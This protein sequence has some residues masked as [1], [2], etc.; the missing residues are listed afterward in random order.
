MSQ[1]NILSASLED[2]E[3]DAKNMHNLYQNNGDVKNS[4]FFLKVSC[5]LHK[6]QKYMKEKDV[7]QSFNDGDCLN[8]SR[9]SDFLSDCLDEIL[10][11]CLSYLKY[12]DDNIDNPGNPEQA[13]DESWK[14]FF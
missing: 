5:E 1:I 10:E 7:A 2:L 13:K 6:Y 9:L 4:R 14:V 8:L 3:I 12:V 11:E